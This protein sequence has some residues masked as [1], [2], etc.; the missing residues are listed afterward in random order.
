MYYIQRK[1]NEYLETIDEFETRKEAIA[2]LKEYRL[3]DTSAY[4]YLSSRACRA[5]SNSK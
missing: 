3:S 2:M 5:W 1:G 4:Y